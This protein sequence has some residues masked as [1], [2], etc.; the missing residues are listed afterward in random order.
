VVCIPH[1]SGSRR[2]NHPSRTDFRGFLVGGNVERWKNVTP[3]D[4]I[5]CNI[6]CNLSNLSGIDTCTTWIHYSPLIQKLIRKPGRD[7]TRVRVGVVS[8]YQSWN[9]SDGGTKTIRA[10]L[11]V[12]GHS[13]CRVSALSSERDP[14]QAL[15]CPA[16]LDWYHNP[17]LGVIFIASS[18][19]VSQPAAIR[20]SQH[21]RCNFLLKHHTA[22]L[23]RPSN[24]NTRPPR[25]H[26]R[27]WLRRS[28]M[29]P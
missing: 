26:R 22:K 10:G 18:V 15:A 24:A 11:F 4:I 27:H 7:E 2:R 29:L 16:A 12:W 14:T 9:L 20:H 6:H 28:Q 25:C 8:M 19:L 3:H 5:T 13:R 1:L 21:P 23:T 17:P